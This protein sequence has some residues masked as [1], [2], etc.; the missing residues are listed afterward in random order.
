M[1]DTIKLSVLLIIAT[2][3]LPS[4]ES[5]LDRTPDAVISEEDIFTSYESFQG[6]A[7]VMY[8]CVIDFG[9]HAWNTAH[10]N[11]DHTIANPWFN[12]GRKYCDGEYWLF[13]NTWQTAYLC[14]NVDTRGI[15]YNPD[16]SGG[17]P[18]SG[19]YPD[20]FKGIRIANNC[21]EKAPLINGTQ[22][23]K[24]LIAGQGYF[25]RA[26]LHWEI[27]VRWGGIPYI[28]KV[29]SAT[30]DLQLPRLSFQA[31][32]ERIV[33]DFDK[34]AE[35]LPFDWDQTETGKKR[36]GF[37]TGSATKGAAMAYKARALLFAGSPLMVH[38]AGGSYEFDNE[39]MR[40]AASA[41]WDVIQLADQGVYGLVDFN[42]YG[43]M[44][45]TKDCTTPW[46]KETIYARLATNW[47]NGEL[48]CGNNM[49][50]WGIGRTYCPV[51]YG[52]GVDWIETAT[53]N[54]V[55][56]FETIDG[57][58]IDDPASVY[59]PMDPW[60]NRDPRFRANIYVD[61]DQV[62]SDP[63]SV[64]EFFVGGS[65][66]KEP[67]LTPY[68]VRKY[69]P[70]GV[71]R[72]DQEIPGFTFHTPLVRLAEMYLIYAEAMNE[73]EGPGGMAP[74][75][76]L[77]A[78]DAVNVIRSRAGMPDVPAKFHNQSDLRDR[79]R[80]ERSV[81]LC[82]EGHR[83]H[84]MRRWYIAHLPEYKPVY[85][86]EFDQGYTYFNKVEILTRTFEQKHYWLP[87]PRTQTELY[88]T[89]PQNP[90]W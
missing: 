64:V 10:E 11:G 28:D 85:S 45:A 14:V 75:A 84:D 16:P 90:G 63:A 43:S 55:D 66:W 80:N 65:D 83:W 76:N 50:Q 30:D 42:D 3:G 49:F 15:F 25:F 44:Y 2:A 60:S 22:E 32:V 38:D 70:E 57:L 37:N 26:L 8:S 1:K 86:L 7:D 12:T 61:G 62:A 24:D 52:G 59:E 56:M 47:W 46:T 78:L 54:F 71:N 77:T 40:R 69:W 89:W 34:A 20:G 4:C 33:E 72:W 31:C 87:F 5:Y 41:A 88:P 53:Q 21:I 67:I 9:R 68:Y 6:Y 35:L 18:P 23:E 13:I 36:E 39:Y 17:P 74:G 58:P 48:Y 51:K 27:I 79:I 82:F 81:E 29:Y 73:A 19:V